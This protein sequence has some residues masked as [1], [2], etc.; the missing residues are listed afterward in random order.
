M[1]VKL[2][3]FR[4]NG[5]RKDFSLAD[6]TTVI[7]RSLNCDLRVPLESVSRRHCELSISPEGMRVTDMGSSNGTYVNNERI[8]GEVELSAGDRLTVGPIVFTVQIDGQPEE[9]TADQPVVAQGDGGQYPAA[10]LDE[11]K[12]SKPAAIVDI[13]EEVLLQSSDSTVADAL[14]GA[15]DQDQGDVGDDLAQALEA[16]AAEGEQ[17]E[18]EVA[19]GRDEEEDASR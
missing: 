7:G 2:V 18:P 19:P 14:V 16:L 15:E 3:V 11:G 13:A 12:E 4:A 5:Q 1:D 10:A 17:A 9:I 6:G 8:D